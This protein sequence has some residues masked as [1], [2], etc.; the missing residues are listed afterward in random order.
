MLFSRIL[1]HVLARKGPQSGNV[2][3]IQLTNKLKCCGILVLFCVHL[4]HVMH[5]CLSYSYIL[6]LFDR[7]PWAKIATCSYCGITVTQSKIA[8]I[9]FLHVKKAGQDSSSYP[10]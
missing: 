3:M 9:L 6:L 2:H 7:Y 8:E 10:P 4:P 1:L 5:P